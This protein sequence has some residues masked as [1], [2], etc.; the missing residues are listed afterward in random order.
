MVRTILDRTVWESCYLSQNA[1]WLNKY[2]LVSRSSI[3]WC[4]TAANNPFFIN[5][6]CKGPQR[7]MP[8][9]IGSKEDL[10]S[11]NIPRRQL[12]K[13]PKK[14]YNVKFRIL[15]CLLSLYATIIGLAPYRK[16]LCSS[17]RIT[18]Q[19]WQKLIRRYASLVYTSSKGSGSGACFSKV[20]IIN[21]LERC[22]CLRIQD[23]R[24]KS[25]ADNMVKPSFKKTKWTVLLVRTRAFDFGPEKSW[26]T[27]ET[28]P[29][30]RRNS[31]PLQQGTFKEKKSL[32]FRAENTIIKQQQISIMWFV[33]S[34]MVLVQLR[35]HSRSLKSCHSLTHHFNES[36]V[37]RCDVV[38][39]RSRPCAAC[40]LIATSKGIEGY[41]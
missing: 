9:N 3:G 20:L 22:C 31:S 34:C 17:Y 4:L 19:H 8:Q 35:C 1:K 40:S 27:F 21:G 7:N 38:D 2:Q 32:V 23:R 30:P 12:R 5:I 24:F 10:I 37:P 33:R 29:R 41:F 13:P 28:D 36:W 11:K 14:S 25:F 39:V 16:L 26:G 15:N 18:L 6:R